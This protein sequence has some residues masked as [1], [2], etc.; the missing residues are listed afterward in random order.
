MITHKQQ[1]KN[2]IKW[3]DSLKGGKKGF[4]KT[5]HVLGVDTNGDGEPDKFCCLGVACKVLNVD[6]EFTDTSSEK[7]VPLVGL[8]NTHGVFKSSIKGYSY[9]TSINDVLYQTDETFTNVRK[10]ILKH[11]DKIFIEPVANELMT[12]YGESRSITHR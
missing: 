9:L 2:A 10:F 3:I 6:V 7:L 4:K 11:L 1:A 12:H 8:Y 5:T